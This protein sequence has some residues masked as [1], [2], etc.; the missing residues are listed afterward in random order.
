VPNV[1][2]TGLTT[3]IIA[4]FWGRALIS[5]ARDNALAPP[6]SSGSIDSA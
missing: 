5:I 2:V 6:S 4:I 3:F 1:T